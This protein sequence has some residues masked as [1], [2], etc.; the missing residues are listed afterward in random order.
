MLKHE[1]FWTLLCFQLCCSSFNST[2]RTY[3][4]SL[5]WKNISDLHK[6]PDLG[7]IQHPLEQI[8]TPTETRALSP[9][10]SA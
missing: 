2:L 5:L 6:S 4:P 8:E 7:P 3:F 9:N 1:I 10:I